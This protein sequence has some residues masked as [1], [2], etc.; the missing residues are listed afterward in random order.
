MTARDP[1]TMMGRQGVVPVITIHDAVD[2]CA[3][4]DA[5]AEAG[6]PVVEITMRTPD[7]LRAIELAAEGVPHATVGAGT[8]TTVQEAVAAIDRGAEFI[9]SPGIDDGVIDT[10]RR[11]RIAVVPGVATPTEVMRARVMGVD[12]VKLFPVTAL[13]GLSLVRSLSA[14]WP[15]MTFVPSGGIS[16]ATAPEYLSSPSVLAVGGSWMLDRDALAERRWDDVRAFAVAARTVVGDR[17]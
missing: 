7:A 10:A 1:L 2:A 3:I 12:T 15:S 6:F 11:N 5:L 8:V 17:T 9:V 13:G 16:A 14:V 4:V